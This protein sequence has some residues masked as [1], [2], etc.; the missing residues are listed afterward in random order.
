V[1]FMVGTHDL[2]IVGYRANGEEIAVFENENF[3]F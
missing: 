2:S 3:T 1:D